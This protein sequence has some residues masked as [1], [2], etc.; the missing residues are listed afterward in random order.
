MTL[1]PP[2]IWETDCIQCVPVESPPHLSFSVCP[3]D[4]IVDLLD[5]IYEEGV[6]RTEKG[7]IL[8]AP[9]LRIQAQNITYI[10]DLA[11]EKPQFCVTCK[12]NLL[13]DYKEFILV[14]ETLYYDFLTQTGY[15][16]CGR[17]GA[18]PW[19]VGGEEIILQQGGELIVR[20][21]YVSTSETE[22]QDIAIRSPCITLSADQVITAKNL[23]L[24]VKN[25]PLAWFPKLRLDLKNY[26]RSPF[27]VKFGWGGFLGSYVSLLYQFASFRDF[28]ATAR[29]DGFFGKGLGGGIETRYNPAWRPTQFYTRNYYANDIPLDNPERRDRYRFQGTYSDRIYGFAIKGMYDV[30]SDPQMAA[31]YQTKDFNLKTAGRTQISLRKQESSWIANLFTRVRVTDFQSVNQELPS[32][33]LNFHPFEIPNTGLIFENTFQAAYLDYVFSDDIRNAQDFSSARV[34][35]YPFFY[36]PF[37][38]GPVVATPEAGLIGIGYSNTPG[39]GSAGQALGEFGLKIETALSKLGESWKHVVEPYLHYQYLTSPRSPID[40]HYIFT[41]NDG[42]DRLNVVRFGIRNSFFVKVPCG[43]ER[44]FWIDLWANAFFNTPT[45]PQ[46]IPRVYLNLEWIPYSRIFVAV[47]SG[48][49]FP[50]N[51]LDYYNGRIDWTLNENLAFG[52]EYRHRSRFDWRKAD[53]YN[54]ILES[55]RTQEELLASPLSDRR[56]TI[57]FRIFTRVTP[58]WTAKFDLR[59]GWNRKR[60]DPYLEYQIELTTVVLQHWLLTFIYDK[61]EADNRYS[62]SLKLNPGPPPKRKACF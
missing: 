5:P 45:I 22:T 51:Q 38:F 31:D 2:M 15:L 20:N 35:T 28:T 54:F 60:Q 4:V 59:H 56:D 58:D 23:N 55:T 43:I 6:L 9:D 13:V 62:F 52:F 11:S 39:G 21:G 1:D 33:Q 36:R 61:R 17:T 40:H 47:E 14:G 32:L 48:W 27:A 16:T 44:P 41:I 18:P 42:W 25:V 57:L 26:G 50:N 12:G 8:T 10:R 29:L 49:Y 46:T 34:A 30:V 24:R 19:Y 53:F 3:E 37:I 7:G